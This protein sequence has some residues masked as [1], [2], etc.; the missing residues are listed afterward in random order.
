MKSFNSYWAT[1][2]KDIY[3]KFIKNSDQFSHFI[4]MHNFIKEFEI[5]LS[6]DIH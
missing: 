3:I 1:R 4:K 6:T 2:T 5:V